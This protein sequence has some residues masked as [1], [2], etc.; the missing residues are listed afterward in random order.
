MKRILFITSLLMACLT[1]CQQNFLELRDP[2]KIPTENLFTSASNV[3]AAVTGV[4]SQL[5]PIYNNSY[6][7]FGEMASDNAY[8]PVSA[9]ARYFFSIFGVEE[10][11][12]NLQTMWTDSYRC[13]SRANTVLAH[14]GTVAMDTTLR[15]RYL[16]EM[17]F[18]RALNYF[19]LVRIWGAVP[20]V[21]EDL[22]ADYQK[23]YTYGRTPVNEVY[24]QVVKDLQEAATALPVTY[25]AGD[26]G[27]ATRSAAKGLLGKVYLTQGNY[28]QAAA[29]LGEL[30]P[31]TPTAGN[32]ASVHALLTTSFED[33]F[34][35]G[36]EMNKEI[37][38]AV[39]YLSGGIGLGSGFASNFLPTYSGTDIIKAGLSGGP[40]VRQDLA[41][42]FPEGDRR[43]ALSVGYYT[44]GNSAAT[45]DY[46]TR[47]YIGNGAPFARNDGDNDW[48]VLRYADV[49]LMYAEA[50]N[51]SG[52]STTA[53]TYLNAVR[54]RA[55]LAALTTSSPSEL[56]LA[57]ENER[58]LELSYE[59]H[60]WFDLIRTGRLLP[61]MNAFYEKY[62]KIASTPQVPNNGLFVNSGGS[63]VQ[64]QPYQVLFPL[65]LAELQYSSQLTQ[66]DGY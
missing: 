36:N 14:A 48:I 29:V 11:N 66:N 64:V 3:A 27:R 61:V 5:Q 46:Y 40:V 62:A 25:S 43:K 44:K 39:R 24:A 49:L 35:T 30:I 13:I 7:V 8:E 47:K 33:V 45:S 57:L 42:A 18:I 6:F 19:N 63:L 34:S 16:A 1:A 23:A 32:L 2:T 12:P 22:G 37:L 50:L 58:R 31:G 65:P 52:S 53:L 41:T 60:R 51:E 56:R 38:F 59:G 9:N 10:N 54:S 28:S 15:N 4:Y 20:L 17:K 55:G 26:L 21:T